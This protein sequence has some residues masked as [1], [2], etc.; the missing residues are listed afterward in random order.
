N[1]FKMSDNDI[2][3]ISLIIEEMICNTTMHSKSI[4]GAYCYSQ[5]YIN[6]LE[7]ILID[8]GIG[9]KK[10]LEKNPEYSA[11][12]NEESILK[13]LEFEV[14]NGEGRGHGLFIMKEI[15]KEIGGNILL[16]S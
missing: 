4:S 7:F 8:N 9:I 2:D 14:T 6:S 1:N 12:T 3:F 13:A 11:L 5:K 10:S 15:V 16:L